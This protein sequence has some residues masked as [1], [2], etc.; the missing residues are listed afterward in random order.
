M[1][2]CN[3]THP[4]PSGLLFSF[5]RV[6]ARHGLRLVP[7][8]L[9]FLEGITFVLRRIIL[10]GRTSENDPVETEVGLATSF[11]G[12]QDSRGLKNRTTATASL[13]MSDECACCPS[14]FSIQPLDP[15][16]AM[17]AAS[18]SSQFQNQEQCRTALLPLLNDDVRSTL[19]PLFLSPI[20]ATM[21]LPWS[22]TPA[23]FSAF[24]A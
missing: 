2:R 19:I 4:L 14:T 9:V 15:R 10:N 11:G 22:S 20:S 24:S 1:T 17:V 12:R 7:T 16:L 5:E 8:T 21:Y 6:E 13:K 3:G 23:S 18:R